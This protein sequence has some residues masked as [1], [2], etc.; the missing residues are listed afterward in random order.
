MVVSL[1]NNLYFYGCFAAYTTSV[2]CSFLANASFSSRRSLLCFV[3]SRR[4]QAH[5]G[6]V[7]FL[8]GKEGG[9]PLIGCQGFQA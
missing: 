2:I 7:G 1:G 8:V 4:K 5:E 6:G 9:E 3:K